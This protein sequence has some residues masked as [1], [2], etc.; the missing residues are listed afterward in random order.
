MIA[1]APTGSLLDGSGAEVCAHA[2]ADSVSAIA[3]IRYLRALV[4]CMGLTS[5]SLI[6]CHIGPTNW[7]NVSRGA[8][9]FRAEQ[10][11]ALA[12][13]C[14]AGKCRA[15]R[16]PLFAAQVILPSCHVI[17]GVRPKGAATDVR[18]SSLSCFFASL[19]QT[20]D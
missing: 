7:P 15:V 5:S 17:F 1:P 16:H 6:Y 8:H 18:A 10:R 12:L 2:P 13:R 20:N 4:P 19:R 14:Y 9:R 11:P 3:V